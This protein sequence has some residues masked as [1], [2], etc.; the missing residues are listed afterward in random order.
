MTIKREAPKRSKEVSVDFMTRVVCGV[1]EKGVSYTSKD[2][3]TL[4]T[5]A[6]KL[7]ATDAIVAYGVKSG[8]LEKTGRTKGTAYFV[9]LKPMLEEKHIAYINS[10]FN[11]DAPTAPAEVIAPATASEPVPAPKDSVS[12]GFASHDPD[13][14]P[15]TAAGTRLSN[16]WQGQKIVT[17]HS[18]HTWLVLT[19][20][21][22]IS[23]VK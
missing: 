10:A 21:I 20:K 13:K 4:V 1:L 17:D 9:R 7:S 19:T 16:V 23:E 14:E 8:Y 12:P 22:L 2:I 6:F 11:P 5:K 3:G 15:K 18:G